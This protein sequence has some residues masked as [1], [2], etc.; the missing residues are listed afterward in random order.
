MSA[1][2]VADRVLELR[3]RHP[4]LVYESYSYTVSDSYLDIRF[5]LLLEPNVEF[6]PHVSVPLPRERDQLSQAMIELFAFHLGL[7]ETISYWKAACPPQVVIAA[8]TLTRAQESWWRDLYLHG[9]GQ[10]FFENGVDFTAP[11]FLTFS[12]SGPDHEPFSLSRPPDGDLL[13]LGGGKDSA[14]ALELLKQSSTDLAVMV[15]NPI[16]PAIESAAIAGVGSPLVAQRNIDPTL[17]ELN[18]QGYLNGHTPFSAYLAFL[19][20]FVAS[21]HGRRHAIVANERG[22]GEENLIYRGLPINH[23]Y[24]K[25]VHFER[26]FRE[27]CAHHLTQDVSYFSY[28]RPLYDLQVAALFAKFPQHHLS[29]RSCNVGQ[30]TDSWCGSCPKC[31]YVYLSLFPFLGDDELSQVFGGDLFTHPDIQHHV[32]ALVGLEGHKPFEC[33]GTVE[34]SVVAVMLGMARC[35]ASGIP[36]PAF[37]TTVAQAL[38]VN[39]AA[40]HGAKH[41]LTTNW[42]SEHFLP[43]RYSG[44]LRALVTSHMSQ[45]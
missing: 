16:R 18:R 2:A 17:L 10:F 7:M 39:D 27:Y 42:G 14:V 44:E 3:R 37:L 36:C 25:S 34:E 28:L 30:K 23:Q 1:R 38:D 45:P 29:F 43:D 41:W 32:K 5:R 8:G 24:S 33:V 4:R 6:T 22:S 20:V 40:V 21:L 13:L 12:A 15:L 31:A 35:L 19:G 26:G 9:L 11:D